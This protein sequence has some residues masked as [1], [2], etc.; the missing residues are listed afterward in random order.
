MAGLNED[1]DGTR[2]V[3]CAFCGDAS[4]DGEAGREPGPSLGNGTTF[5]L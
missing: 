4:L 2:E 3:D 1:E 5:V